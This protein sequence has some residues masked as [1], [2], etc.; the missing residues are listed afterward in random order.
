MTLSIGV[1]LFH[2]IIPA[3]V[4]I[5]FAGNIEK[6]IDSRF[7]GNDKWVVKWKIKKALRK[8]H[9]KLVTTEKYCTIIKSN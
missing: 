9:T 7:H 2:C 8:K 4:G 1:A 5:Q 3:E 6:I